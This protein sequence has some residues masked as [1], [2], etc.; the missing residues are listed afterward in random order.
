MINVAKAY[1][2]YRLKDRFLF[3]KISFSYECYKFY[4]VKLSAVFLYSNYINVYI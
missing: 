1:L 2:L 3:N 4:I